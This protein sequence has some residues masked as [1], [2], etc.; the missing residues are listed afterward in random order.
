MPRL[1]LP[2]RRKLY[3]TFENWLYENG[4]SESDKNLYEILW[5]MPLHEYA[6]SL[7]PK[8]LEF[9]FTK[10]QQ[11]FAVERIDYLGSSLRKINDP[12][13]LNPILKGRKITREELLAATRRISAVSHS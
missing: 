3:E 11:E 8:L 9:F 7:H 1:T 2:E 12:R 4:F 5:F 13:D 10:Q 6:H